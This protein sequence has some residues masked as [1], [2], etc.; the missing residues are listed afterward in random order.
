[1]NAHK[2]KI[3]LSKIMPGMSSN[4]REQCNQLI[5]ISAT[6]AVTLQEK[7]IHYILV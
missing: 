7:H 4:I 2:K 3:A 1:M 6:N 5:S